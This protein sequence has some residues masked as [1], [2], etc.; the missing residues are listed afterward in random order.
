MEP[1]PPPGAN[2]SYTSAPFAEVYFPKM[3]SMPTT[4]SPSS[5][6]KD[7]SHGIGSFRGC[8]VPQKDSKSCAKPATQK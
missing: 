2:A 5:D 1:T 7:S 8:F 3:L 4:S 6:P